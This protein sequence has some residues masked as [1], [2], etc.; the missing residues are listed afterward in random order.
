V[1]SSC[2]IWQRLGTEMEQEPDD[3]DRPLSERKAELQALRRTALGNRATQ[4]PWQSG[5][6]QTIQHGVHNH[7]NNQTRPLIDSVTNDWKASDKE[8]ACD[9]TGEDPAELRFCDLDDDESCPNTTR[10]MVKSRRFRRMFMILAAVIAVLYHSWRSYI[11]PWLQYDWEMK[12]GFLPERVNGTY[13]IAQGGANHF[14]GTF[15][16]SLDPKLLPGGDADPEGERRLIF[17]GDVHGCKDE[18]L[19]LLDKV[20]FNKQTD[21]VIPTGDVISKGPD[22]IRVMDELVHIGAESVR[23]NHEDR[24][25]VMAK[26]I[27]DSNLP[28]PTA[29]ATSVGY[30]RDAKLLKALK[31]EHMKYLRDMPLILHIP[32]LPQAKHAKRKDHINDHIY[33]VHAGLVPHVALRRQIPYMVMN[34]RSIDRL[35]HMPSSKRKTQRGDNRPWMELWNWYN[36]RLFRGK[37]IEKFWNLDAPPVTESEV[38]VGLGWFGRAWHAV[39]GVWKAVP[40]TKPQVVVYGHDSKAGLQIKRWSK[41]L[42]SGCVSGGQLT[43][44]ILTADGKTEI[45]QVDCKNYR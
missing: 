14:E 17:I 29:E 4:L 1:D 34:M 10:R 31:K 22:S 43:A 13:G 15:M 28:L 7:I 25:L 6:P 21:H 24:L 12:E 42:D 35:T 36:D 19:E 45:V 3:Y 37:S 23:G 2:D 41:G 26:T 44:M 30:A 39:T 8:K 5:E 11:G 20:G 27:L 18:L 33:V 32:S 16:K 38:D 9:I 40:K